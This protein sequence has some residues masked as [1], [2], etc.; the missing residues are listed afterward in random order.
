MWYYLP[1]LNKI[2]SDLDLKN[3]CLYLDFGHG[4]NDPGCKF[5]DGSLEKD[6]NLKFGLKV[7][8]YLKP[9]FSKVYIS[10]STDKTLSLS[11]RAAKMKELAGKFQTVHGYSFHCNAFNK[12][13]NGA[14]WLLSISTKTNH[15]D[16]KF[17]KQFLYDYAKEFGIISR[18]IVQRSGKDG[19]DYY[20]LHKYTP[21]NC[22]VKYIELFFGDNK[23][24]CQIGQSKE[25]FDKAT[26]FLASY[27]LKRYGITIEKKEPESTAMYIVQ[28]GAFKHK[29]NAENLVEKLQEKGFSAII[30]KIK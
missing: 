9:F 26:F 18:G 1:G 4:G 2:V 10:R 20:Y 14:L 12:V 17:C 29:K 16:Y 19:R 23:H 11:T 27:I 28:A 25:Y 22:K 8:E 15:T 21:S 5:Y 6:Y 7:F 24:D 13:S 3:D 30:K